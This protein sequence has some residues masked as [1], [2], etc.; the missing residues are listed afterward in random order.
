MARSSLAGLHNTNTKHFDVFLEGVDN[1][2]DN[3]DGEKQRERLEGGLWLAGSDARDSHSQQSEPRPVVTKRKLYFRHSYQW[4][5]SNS[6][7]P[8]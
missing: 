1:N 7:Q 3:D 4:I 2:N 5:N 8:K 6:G